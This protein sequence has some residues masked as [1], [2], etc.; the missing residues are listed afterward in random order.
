ML[1]WMLAA[2]A[3]YVVKGLCGF[4]NTL[5]FTSILAY[6][7]S[8]AA[9]TPVDLLVGCPAN[10]W[11]A[12]RYRREAK[13]RVWLPMALLM[14]AGVIPGVFFLKNVD[15]RTVK[16][17]FGLVV[18]GV[19]VEMLLRERCGGVSKGSR[20]VMTIIGVLSGVLCGLYG[21]GALLA[22]Y[23]S[24]TTS[25]SRAFKGSLSMVF[26][27]ENAFR[28]VLYTVTGVFTW[29]IVQRVLL[30]LPCM[31]LG[32]FIGTKSAGHISE[33]NAKRVVIV[34]LVVSGA[35]LIAA[36]L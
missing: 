20:V 7:E 6:G 17:I 9:I 31:A 15:A 8:N 25:D 1:I 35:A 36:N 22:A 3:A 27:L 12:W 33:K 34:M 26:F 21:V 5:V 29:Q 18:I 23:F 2:V 4:A 14:F 28:V 16:L 32:L 24:R 19:G 10:A 30:M 13:W 11:M